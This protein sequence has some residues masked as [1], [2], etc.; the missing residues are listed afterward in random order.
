MPNKAM[1]YPKVNKRRVSA[2]FD[3]VV[4]HTFAVTKKHSANITAD[5]DI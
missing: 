3:F 2:N 5:R 1:A 4:L